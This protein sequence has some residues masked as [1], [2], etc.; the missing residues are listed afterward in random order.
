MSVPAHLVL[1]ILLGEDDA[2]GKTV[3]ACP[4]VQW[5]EGKTLCG[6]CGWSGDGVSGRGAGDGLA[7]WPRGSWEG[8][9]PETA[10]SPPPS[11]RPCC[12]LSPAEKGAR[13]AAP[14]PGTALKQHCPQLV[15]PLA[16]SWSLGLASRIN[17]ILKLI[18]AEITAV[19]MWLFLQTQISPLITGSCT[20]LMITTW[21]KG[22]NKWPAFREENN[23]KRNT[24]HQNKHPHWDWPY[25][26][27]IKFLPQTLT[28]P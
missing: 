21:V 28:V 24:K 1:H 3:V 9:T 23:W 27:H 20:L 22:Q 5:Q 6:S 10:A 8:N 14:E 16:I 2:A 12:P 7:R 19:V 15:L 25:I 26:L 13:Q 17:T 18:A 11:A 4:Q